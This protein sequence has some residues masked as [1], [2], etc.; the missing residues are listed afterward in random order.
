N[1][2]VNPRL[3]L[4]SD[5]LPITYELDLKASTNES[6]R[7]NPDDMDLEKFLA[8]LRRELNQ[9]IIEIRSQDEL[10]EATDDLCRALVTALRA[11]TAKRRPSSHSKQWWSS[12]ISSLLADLSRKERWFRKHRTPSVRK[13]WLDARKVFYHAIASPKEL[14]WRS[15]VRDL[16]RVN[17][18]EVL[19]RVRHRPR[20]VFPSL[21]DPVTGEAAVDHLARGRILGR[22]WF[23]SSAEEV[24]QE[25]EGETEDRGNKDSEDDEKYN[26]K[27]DTNTN[28]NDKNKIT[29]NSKTT[30]ERANA[31]VGNDERELD[32]GIRVEE[33]EG[34]RLRALERA[35]MVE[36][37]EIVEER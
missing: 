10:D 8:V 26:N 5:H 32:E 17:V 37:L 35:K 15:F 29:K 30:D 24:V 16:E 23:G 6:A 36:A 31:S 14:A 9:P 7:Y 34:E 25:K 3:G 27:K 33:R 12:E 22:A 2:E 21:V 4:G 1:V 18:Y 13:C 20:S 11:S 28:R 19:D